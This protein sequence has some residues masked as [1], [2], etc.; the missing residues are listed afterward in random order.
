LILLYVSLYGVSDD[1]E[2]SELAKT[3]TYV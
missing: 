3:Q 2:C 1:D